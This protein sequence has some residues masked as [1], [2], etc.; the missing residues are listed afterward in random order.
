MIILGFVQEWWWKTKYTNKQGWWKCYQ[1]SKKFLKTCSVPQLVNQD[2]NFSQA[3]LCYFTM[4][5]IHFYIHSRKYHNLRLSILVDQFESIPIM[6]IWNHKKSWNRF[7]FAKKSSNYYTSLFVQPHSN[8]HIF[9][10]IIQP[11][12]FF[13]WFRLR[14]GTLTSDSNTLCHQLILTRCSSFC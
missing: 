13:S 3:P 14:N 2:D 6:T 5:C 7:W 10:S 8:Y 12:C 1:N 11:R 4:I 9:K